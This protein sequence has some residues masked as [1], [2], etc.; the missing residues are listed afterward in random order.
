MREHSL[1]EFKLWLEDAPG[2]LYTENESNNERLWNS[3]NT[4]PYTKDAFHRYLIEGEKQ[5]VN[6]NETG[7]KACVLYR[8][9]LEPVASK[10]LRFRF[11][12]GYGSPPV[13]HDV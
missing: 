12:S 7:T 6:P 13:F 3:P 11:L 4:Q 9:Q 5:A 1:G 10:V 2:Q 8:L